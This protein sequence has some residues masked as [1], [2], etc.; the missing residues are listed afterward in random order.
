MIVVKNHLHSI[1]SVRSC[2]V[3]VDSSQFSFML[4]NRISTILSCIAGKGR[5][6][7]LYYK[8]SFL[9]YWLVSIRCKTK[10]A[11]VIV[12]SWHWN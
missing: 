7:G 1:W 4:S 9:F 12:C 10:V 8:I 11:I 6:K 5:R 3:E 2:T